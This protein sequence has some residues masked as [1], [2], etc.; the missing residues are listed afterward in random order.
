MGLEIVILVL[1]GLAAG[2]LGAILGLGGGVIMLP[3]TQI[4]LH[5]DPVMAVGTTLVAVVFTS[6]SA[7]QGH[8]K[9]G[10]VW[11]KTA[12]FIGS[13]GTAGVLLGSY[14]FN[15]YFSQNAA[16]LNSILGVLFIVMAV[17]MGKESYDM[18]KSRD[19]IKDD[20]GEAE[21]P[22]SWLG[23]ILLGLC[24][25]TLTGIL[26]IGGGFL[27]VPGLMFIFGVSPHM[28]VG[29]TMMAM[30]PVALIGAGIKWAEGFVYP[31]SGLLLGLGAA[32]GAQLG[33]AVSRHLSVMWMKILFTLVFLILA[34]DYLQ[35]FIR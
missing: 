8:Y 20:S 3:A 19:G 9:A 17:K 2:I 18:W 35:A 1:T 31:L 32:I 23:L 26:G 12:V 4:L 28:A 29:T 13:G 10:H 33:V 15:S 30:L 5:Y 34:L 16:A 22:D 7:S 24:T 6:L 14:V 27:M 11:I 25:G 21:Q